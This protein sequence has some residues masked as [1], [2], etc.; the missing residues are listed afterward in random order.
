MSE[1][2]SLKRQMYVPSRPA[3]QAI[4][5]SRTALPSTPPPPPPSS[6]D[7]LLS[8]TLNPTFP[9]PYE[10]SPPLLLLL[11]L[12]FLENAE[13]A[14]DESGPRTCRTPDRR[15]INANHKRRRGRGD[16]LSP[17]APKPTVDKKLFPARAVRAAT[18]IRGGQVAPEN[19][20][21]AAAP[22]ARVRATPA[23]RP[24]LLLLLSL[25]AGAC[26]RWRMQPPAPL[27][28]GATEPARPPS[29]ALLHRPIQDKTALPLPEEPNDPPATRPPAVGPPLRRSPPRAPRRHAVASTSRMHGGQ[30]FYAANEDRGARAPAGSRPRL[31]DVVRRLLSVAVALVSLPAGILICKS[32]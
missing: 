21:P 7:G 9:C 18:L 19:K 17:G 15:E 30:D 20:V 25:R 32:A 2:K 23:L 27:A 28:T 10:S 12:L 29:P 8:R 5:Q 3:C 22:C 16:D 24:E 31:R 13:A 14:D 11:L 26:N 4:N 6:R 1:I